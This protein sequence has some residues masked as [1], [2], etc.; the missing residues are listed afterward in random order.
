VR[1]NEQGVSLMKTIIPVGIVAALVSAASAT[2]AFVVTSA[3]IKNGT[4]QMADISA[5][6]K[7][8]LKGNRGPRGFTGEAGPQGP[9]GPR[10]A[11][12]IR[13]EM[14][15]GVGNVTVTASCAPGEIALSGGGGSND[16]ALRSSGPVSGSQAWRVVV[17]NPASILPI[18]WAEVLCAR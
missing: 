12:E 10:Y 1:N 14:G 2:A 13:R 17:N 3:S 7:R 8:A 15:A 11:Y 4:I 16:G 5:K 18:A 9:A 6:A